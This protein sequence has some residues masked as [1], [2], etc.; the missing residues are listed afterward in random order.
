MSVLLRVQQRSGEQ[1][2]KHRTTINRNETSLDRSFVRETR[3]SSSRG[4][5]EE[6]RSSVADLP[7]RGS[8]LSQLVNKDCADDQ[9]EHHSHTRELKPSFSII[10]ICLLCNSLLSLSLSSFSDHVPSG[11]RWRPSVHFG[12]RQSNG[13]EFKRRCPVSTRDPRSDERGESSTRASGIHRHAEV[14]N[15]EIVHP[16]WRSELFRKL[17]LDVIEL[18]ADES[19]PEGVFVEDTAVVCDGLALICRPGLPGRLKEVTDE[20]CSLKEDRLS[21]RLKPSERSFDAKD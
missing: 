17:G 18:P 11:R 2:P 1:S 14:E 13:S 5:A 10:F 20:G 19:L 3:M 9:R 4:L 7:E 12:H 8:E 16:S 21:L 6:E 15:D